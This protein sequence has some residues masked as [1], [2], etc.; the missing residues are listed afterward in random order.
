MCRE[1]KG[2]TILGVSMRS[3]MHVHVEIEEDQRWLYVLFAKVNDPGVNHTE[4]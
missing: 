3:K 4:Y 1:T 2:L